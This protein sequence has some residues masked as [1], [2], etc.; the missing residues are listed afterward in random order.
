MPLESIYSSKNKHLCQACPGVEVRT[1]EKN[2][3]KIFSFLCVYFILL[4]R[5]TNKQIAK[6]IHICGLDNIKRKG[7]NFIYV[8]YSHIHPSAFFIL[9]LFIYGCTGTLL[10]PVDFIELWAIQGLLA[11][12]STQASHLWWLFLLQSSDL[13]PDVHCLVVSQHVE[14]SQIRD[15]IPVPCFGRWIL[16]HWTT[17]K[18]LRNCFL[19]VME[20]RVNFREGMISSRRPASQDDI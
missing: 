8:L 7:E 15:R 20:L 1:S 5:H 19:F 12:C 18:V 10:L 17:R 4:G 14:S 16:N 9:Y 3:G 2:S 6:Y 13:V 11:S